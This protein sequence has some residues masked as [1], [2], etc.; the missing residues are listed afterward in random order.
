MEGDLILTN[1]NRQTDGPSV[2]KTRS[3]PT[4][5]RRQRW[6]AFVVSLFA[7]AAMGCL[8]VASIFWTAVSR[9]KLSDASSVESASR[10]MQIG[11]IVIHSGD[12]GCE[13]IKF[14]NRRETTTNN[15]TPCPKQV[16]DA[17]GVPVPQG[18]LH[19]LDAIS[20]SFFGR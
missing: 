14:D 13:Q 5:S 11:T 9:S 20:K 7:I 19:R 1:S 16:L 15:L 3:R 2:V 10:E 12:N 6:R 8:V 17:H 18:T 4:H